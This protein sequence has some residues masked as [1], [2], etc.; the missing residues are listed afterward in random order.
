MKHQ[1]P[2]M[3][4]PPQFP[5]SLPKMCFFCNAIGHT[6][7]YCF[8]KWPCKVCGL[9]HNK[10]KHHGTTY[11]V[12]DDTLGGM[13]QCWEHP[14]DWPSWRSINFW[15]WFLLYQLHSFDTS[16]RE[17]DSAFTDT[18]V[19][20]NAAVTDSIRHLCSIARTDRRA[21]DWWH[22]FNPLCGSPYYI[23]SRE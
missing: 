5:D 13:F 6:E 10:L 9:E 15:I 19:N 8:K 3:S 20:L 12:S 21:D 4:T 22:R 18:S 17:D 7:R 2:Q 23:S 14:R 11:S 1:D 16:D